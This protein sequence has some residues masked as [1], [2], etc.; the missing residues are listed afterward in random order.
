MA[1]CPVLQLSKVRAYDNAR[2]RSAELVAAQ[3]VL[4]RYKKQF[5]SQ[6]NDAQRVHSPNDISNAENGNRADSMTADWHQKQPQ[7]HG[8]SAVPAVAL[9]TFTSVAAVTTRCKI[10][11]RSISALRSVVGFRGAPWAVQHSASMVANALTGQGKALSIGLATGFGAPPYAAESICI[12][13]QSWNR[14]NKPPKQQTKCWSNGCLAPG[15][16]LAFLSCCFPPRHNELAS[17]KGTIQ[18][19]RMCVLLFVLFFGL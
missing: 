14:A 5:A 6:E 3:E 16:T 4:A 19:S 17:C 1:C 18:A 10:G 8:L 11:S 2:Y 9:V 7:P 15:L 12:I 13:H